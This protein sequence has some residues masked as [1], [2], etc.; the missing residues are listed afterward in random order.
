M[1]PLRHVVYS[2]YL[3]DDVGWYGCYSDKLC[4]CFLDLTKYS[5][6]FVLNSTALRSTTWRTFVI[7][8]NLCK[9]LD[10]RIKRFDILVNIYF[11]SISIYS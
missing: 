4:V 2:I 11:S 8:V 9:I 7:E 1:P 5:P 3:G 6:N 10:S